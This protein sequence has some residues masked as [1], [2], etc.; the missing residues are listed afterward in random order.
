MY[1]RVLLGIAKKVARFRPRKKIIIP[2]D[3]AASRKS[4][5]QVLKEAPRYSSG[6]VIPQ[7]PPPDKLKGGLLPLRNKRGKPVKPIKKPATITNKIKLPKK[8]K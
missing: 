1:G 6:R 7:T 2:K 4:I 5:D 3:R 8:R